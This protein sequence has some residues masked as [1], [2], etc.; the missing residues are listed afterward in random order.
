M[1][2]PPPSVASLRGLLSGYESLFRRVAASL[3]DG[4]ILGVFI[5]FLL[6]IVCFVGIFTGHL[7]DFEPGWES[8]MSF[9]LS[10][11]TLVGLVDCISV[12]LVPVLFLLDMYAAVMSSGANVMSCGV[13]C[14]FSHGCPESLEVT[15]LLLFIFIIVN[16]LYH[17]LMESSSKQATLGK[18]LFNIRVT[19]LEGKRISFGK[20][21]AR[22]FCKI[23]SFLILC[24]GFL[25]AGWTKNHQ[26]LHD[27]ITGCLVKAPNVLYSALCQD[28]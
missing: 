4:V 17:A 24:L 13:T 23:L 2:L 12:I 14:S 10:L 1:K 28:E 7:P 5:N 3:I 15:L 21:T 9:V 6:I 19:N 11:M 25:M 18:M 26:A 20:A 27:K 8:R 22:H 16:W